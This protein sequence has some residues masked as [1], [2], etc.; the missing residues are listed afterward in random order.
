MTTLQSQNDDA[1]IVFTLSNLNK[2]AYRR[3]LPRGRARVRLG[4]A[5]PQL[6]RKAKIDAT[7]RLPRTFLF[8]DGFRLPFFPPRCTIDVRAIHTVLAAEPLPLTVYSAAIN[9]ETKSALELKVQ[10]TSE[11]APE[12][13][14]PRMPSRISCP[15]SWSRIGP[16]SHWQN[17]DSL[18]E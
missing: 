12:N 8:V 14:V 3:Q 17:A 2:E 1:V 6:P 16:I 15:G 9:K 10:E 7:H 13:S 4:I 11:L 5:T 18:V